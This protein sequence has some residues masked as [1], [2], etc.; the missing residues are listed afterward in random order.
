MTSTSTFITFPM[1]EGEV[2]INIDEISSFYSHTV[3]TYAYEDR[4]M[5]IMKN[6]ERHDCRVKKVDFEKRIMAVV[7]NQRE[8]GG[9][10][11]WV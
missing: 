9:R 1:G 11:E 7:L 3:A 2:S 4:T 5:V 8:P 10:P 6:G